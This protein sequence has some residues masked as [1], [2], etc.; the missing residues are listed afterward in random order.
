[1][2]PR[3]FSYTTALCELALGYSVRRLHWLQPSSIRFYRGFAGIGYYVEYPLNPFTGR[4]NPGSILPYKFT[5]EDIAA[6]DWFVV[7]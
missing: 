4:P 3:T 2:T 1:M 5:D 7:Q 6:T